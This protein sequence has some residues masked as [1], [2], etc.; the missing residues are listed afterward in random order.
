MVRCGLKAGAAFE[1]SLG[2]DVVHLIGGG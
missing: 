2:I 1:F